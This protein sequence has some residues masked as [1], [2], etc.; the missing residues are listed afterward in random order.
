[1][2]HRNRPA[3]QVWAPQASAVELHVERDGGVTRTPLARDALGWWT[4][5]ELAPGDDYGFVVDGSGPF[6][7]PR[8]PAQPHGV[9]GL[10][11][12]VVLDP[13]AWTD[14]DWSGVDALGAVHYEVHVGTFTP[15]GTLDAAIEE[16][17]RLAD[18]GIE[19]VT[20]MPIAPFP[21]QRGWGYD[22]V[23]MYAVHEAY[24]G[25]E[26]LQRFVNA[27]HARGLGVG[28]DV[29][30]NHQGPDGNYLGMYGP[31]FSHRHQ[32]PWGHGANLDG[33]GSDA[34]RAHIIGAALRWFEDFHVDALRLDAVHALVDDS[35]R[36]LLAELA[37]ETEALSARLGRPLALIAESDRNDP[38]TVT[39]TSAGGLGQTM[40]WADDV[41]HALHAY[42]TGERHGYY[43]DFGSI[44]TLDHALRRVFVHDGS[45]SSFRDELWGAPVPDDIDRRRF[46]VFASNHDQVGNR[47][48]GD[49]PVTSLTPAAYATSL[50]VVLLGPFTPMLFMGEEHGEDAPFQFFS[51]HEAE[52]GEAVT[53]GRI[54]EFASHG[55]E[56]DIEVPDPQDVATFE[57]S[58]IAHAYDASERYARVRAWVATCIGLRERTRDPAAWTRHPVR[59]WEPSPGVLAVEGP[60]RIVANLSDAQLE[61]P[62]DHSHALLGSWGEVSVHDGT[63]TMPAQSVALVG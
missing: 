14:A 46:V 45:Y 8:S 41:H 36:H 55:W 59:A 25:P 42:L 47:A 19:L 53:R 50:A 44:E 48:L 4:G 31:Y 28:L 62:V 30:F 29:V 3:G 1:V 12:H 16:L 26:A 23:G 58:R 63:A 32:T 18:A 60:V 38:L 39:P 35:P 37:D 11:R 2:T 21:G 43:A 15:G 13:D 17:D 49:R 7:D 22:G 57:R 6:P 5:G 56:G 27:A 20:L 9:H 51:D 10:S 24:G 34:V 61:F 54:A 52:L 40:Q 33:P